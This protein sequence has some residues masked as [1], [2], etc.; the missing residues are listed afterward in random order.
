MSKIEEYLSRLR[1]H[2]DL[3]PERADEIVAEVRNH[4]QARA[5]E[6][7]AGGL[8]HDEAAA[9][10]VRSFGEPDHIARELLEGNARHRRPQVLRAL[11]AIAVS[12]GAGFALAVFY[13]TSESRN[14]LS[15]RLMMSITGLD[16]FDAGWLLMVVALVPPALLA[17]MVG[18]R[19]FW[20]LA[21]APA[22]FWIGLCWV[23]TAITRRLQ[24][25]A[26]VR[27][28][29][30]YALIVPALAALLFAGFGW[31]GAR[32]IGARAVLV[33]AIGYVFGIGGA[34]YVLWLA[35]RALALS[36]DSPEALGIAA[37]VAQPA[38]LMLLAGAVLDGRL[39]RG[40]FVVL[41]AV[42]CAATLLAA[43]FWVMLWV[44]AGADLAALTSPNGWF[45]FA[46]CESV[47]GL[48]GIAVYRALV[49]RRPT[50][51]AEGSA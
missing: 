33:R 24:P 3:P 11:G 8:S 21:S 15:I 19:R 7:E 35:V 36:L 39:T 12:V 13:G 51:P 32:L 49:H 10:A 14:A 42:T 37:A 30:F 38:V 34:A 28:Q 16:W 20:W 27:E 25:G 18:G 40:T 22:L 5:A 47:L 4:L 23:A 29:L 2:L 26:N 31:L 45:V 44:D 41:F 43:T 17:G 48:A 9:E 46:A 50:T 1:S 6:L